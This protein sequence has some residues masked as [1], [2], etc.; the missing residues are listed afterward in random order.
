[1]GSITWTPEAT[2]DKAIS[3]SS[4]T[5]ATTYTAYTAQVYLSTG[6]PA[7]SGV[8]VTCSAGTDDLFLLGVKTAVTGS[9]GTAV[10]NLYRVKVGTITVKASAGGVTSAVATARKYIND[11]GGVAADGTGVEGA[12]DARNVTVTASKAAAGSAATVVAKVTDR[13]GN[14]VAGVLVTWSYSGVGRPVSGA[15]MTVGTDTNGQAQLQ[16]TSLADELGESSVTAT[17]TAGNQ[18]LDLADY[19]GAIKSAGALVG[20]YVASG[21]VTFSAPVVTGVTNAEVLAAI[22]KLIA[23]INKQITALQKLL[24]KKK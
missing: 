19:V 12:A 2:T 16:M 7:G 17:I 21:K 24:T 23:S 18:T 22:V 15:D 9:D 8:L 5:G 1:V 10:C 20:N 14:P 4:N 6:L 11:G 3:Q 13:W